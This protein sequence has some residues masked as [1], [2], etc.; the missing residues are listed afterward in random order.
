[1]AVTGAAA[2]CDTMDIDAGADDGGIA[3]APAKI[4]RQ[5]HDQAG[6]RIGG[7]GGNGG[8]RGRRALIKEVGLLRG[9]VFLRVLVI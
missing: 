4:V 1:M 7:G 6:E 3:A 8:R 9:F 5:L 2:Q